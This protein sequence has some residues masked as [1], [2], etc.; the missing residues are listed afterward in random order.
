MFK[1]C[2]ALLC[3]L[4][5]VASC[6]SSIAGAPE[7]TGAPAPT[8][9]S[10][11]GQITEPATTPSAG[12]ASPTGTS[13]TPPSPSAASPSAASSGSPS[14][15][16]AGPVPAGLDQFYDQRLTWSGCSPFATNTDD[17]AIYR[18]GQLQCA[19][20]TVPMAYAD[21]TGTTVRIGVLRKVATD[22]SQRIGSLLINPGGP[23]GSAMSFVGQ[24]AALGYG[25]SLNAKFDLVGFDPRGI[26]SSVPLIRCQT[27]AELDATRAK[28]VRSNTPA[29]VAA[30][31][32]LLKNYAAEC[33]T[34]TG[35][36]GK[37]DGRTFLANVGTRDV[38]SDMD[39]LRAVLGDAKLTYAGFSYGTRLGYVYAEKFPTN[40]RAMVLDGAVDPTADPATEMVD[41]NKGFQQAFVA[42]ATSCAQ[43]P[44]CPLGTDPQQATAVFQKLSRPLLTAPLPLSDGRVLSYS[45]ATLGVA[46]ALYDS[47]NWKVLTSGIAQ[48]AAGNG[49]TL[50]ALADDYYQRGKTGTYAQRPDSFNAIRCVDDPRMTDPAEVTRL[51]ALE[52]AAAP[53]QASGD[54]AADI[55]DLCA[56]WP[57][58]STLAP[59]RL[60]TPGLPQVLVIST[61]GDPAT[62]YA[63]GVDLARQL[64]ARLL[65][66]EGTRHTAY[67]TAQNAC[68]DNAGN[69]YLLQLALPA[70]GTRCS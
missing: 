48:L 51:N 58:P 9:G 55:P 49:A 19:Y 42:F 56:Y 31:N 11:A 4:L 22:A 34:A 21:P 12:S 40:V 39:V 37:V 64:G 27:D 52:A 46:N 3:A 23:G 15:S 62:P 28:T 45:D 69:A 70:D 57:V 67:L 33:V 29:A 2:A 20:L 47:A 61:T 43:Q 66:F 63:S 6:S 50:M 35:D 59:H 60:Q 14:S 13:S 41:Q 24:L 16:P 54:P 53:F 5:L 10:A 36:G 17:A 32:A 44:G 30:A 18:S 65:T 38:A 68:V 7:P 8:P 25:K 1:R 26:G